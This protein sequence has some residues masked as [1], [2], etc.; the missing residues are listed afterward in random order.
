MTQKQRSLTTL[1]V[2]VVIAGAFGA[3]AWFGVYQSGK[4]EEAAKERTDTLFD[5]KKD[6]VQRLSVTAQG[7]TTEAERTPSVG[8]GDAGA[9]AR[10]WR[11]VAP[12]H[13]GGDAATLDAVAEKLAGLKQK[14]EIKAPGDLASYGLDK[15]R[16]KVVA[17]LSDGKT[18]ELDIGA[19]NTYDGTIYAKKVGDERVSILEASVRPPLDKSTFDLRDK[20]LFAFEE[21]ALERLDVASGKSVYALERSTDGQWKLTAPIQ[22]PADTAK[23]N[24]VANAVRGLRAVRFATEQSSGQDLARYGLSKPVATVEMVLAND[25]QQKT[26]V[27]GEVTEGDTHHVFAKRPE[28][29][30]VAEVSAG[31]LKDLD[32]SLTDLRDKTVLSFDPAQVAGLRFTLGSAPPFDAKKI[33]AADGG[34]ESW[35]LGAPSPGPAKKWRLAALLTWLHDLKGSSI[36]AEQASDSQLENDGLKPPKKVVSVLGSGDRVIAELFVGSD[37]GGKTFLKSAVRPLVFQVD[38]SR[39][40]QLPADAQDLAEPPPA[41]DGGIGSARAASSTPAKK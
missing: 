33:A 37:E 11:I 34:F 24:Q 9:T 35:Q 18:A 40:S 38:T 39:L 1:A 32:Q 16:I 14:R 8:G 5:F 19:D 7:E 29:P 27:L 36:A 2:I 4:Q 23:A 6:D 21:S 31:I 12:I 3:Y 13:A 22:L 41:G 25:P 30:Y 28:L 15:P 10:E 26:V 20:R 17:T